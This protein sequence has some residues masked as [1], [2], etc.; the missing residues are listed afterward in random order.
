[1][2]I[3]SGTRESA[4]LRSGIREIIISNEPRY[5]GVK[6]LKGEYKM[7]PFFVAKSLKVIE[8]G[9]RT[10]VLHFDSVEDWIIY[11][12]QQGFCPSVVDLKFKF[13]PSI[14]QKQSKISSKSTTSLLLQKTYFHGPINNTPRSIDYYTIHTSLLQINGLIFC[15]CAITQTVTKKTMYTQ[16]YM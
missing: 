10:F 14:R 4:I 6:W 13:P 16:C 2:V 15:L 12:S 8:I 9:G 5:L 1:M 3:I 7:A 11:E